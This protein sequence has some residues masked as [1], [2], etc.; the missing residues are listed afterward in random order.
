LVYAGAA[1]FALG[2]LGNAYHH[3]LL[4]KL[5]SG[6]SGYFLPQGGLFSQVVMPHY[7]FECISWFGWNLLLGFKDIPSI[8]FWILGTVAMIGKAKD[9]HAFYKKVF[10]GKGAQP[11]KFDEN[12][13]L[14]FPFIY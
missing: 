11:F 7:F 1:I 12:T 6:A 5:R 14:M 2:E 10:D 9:K 13:K 8:A 4:S 3:Y